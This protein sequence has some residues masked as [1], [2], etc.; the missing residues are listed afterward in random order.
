VKFLTTF[1]IFEARLLPEPMYAVW[2]LSGF[3]NFGGL[4]PKS[5]AVELKRILDEILDSQGDDMV[6]I[7]DEAILPEP[8]NKKSG[9]IFDGNELQ[10]YD[11]YHIEGEIPDDVDWASKKDLFSHPGEF[12]D[13]STTYEKDKKWYSILDA[14]YKVYGEELQLPSIDWSKPEDS[15]TEGE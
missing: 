13:L 4:F 2:L 7:S 12:L 5:L 6:S 8:H 15:Q 9:V 11:D 14:L 10:I 1:K 3:K